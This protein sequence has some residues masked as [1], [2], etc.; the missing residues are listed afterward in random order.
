L[1]NPQGQEDAETAERYTKKA[2]T[3]TN[4]SERTVQREV[5]RGEKLGEVVLAKVAHTS[6]DTGEELDSLAKLPE[7]K[8]TTSLN[9]PPLAKRSVPNR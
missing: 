9:V 6:L 5:R 1:A 2:A 8:E 3:A 7:K 4:T